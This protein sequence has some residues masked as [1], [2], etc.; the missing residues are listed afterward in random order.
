MVI[1]MTEKLLEIHDLKKHF[2]MRAGVLSNIKGYVKAVDGISLSVNKGET[3]GLVGESGC[4]KSTLGRLLLRLIEP[5]SGSC[6]INGVDIY[7]LKHNEMRKLRR[8]V[9]IIFQ[10]PYASLNPKITVGNIIGEPLKIFGIIKDKKVREEKV[11]NLLE[12]VGLDRE[13]FGRFP[14]EFSGGQRQRVCIARALALN[15]KLIV[16]DEAVSALDV[17]IR[18]QILNLLKDLQDKYDLTY[19]FISHDLS[20]VC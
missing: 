9:Q 12:V 10:D 5:T 18:S 13:H 8:D 14:H 7:K 4:G 17:S 15:P 20:V 19:I 2:A 1:V 11:K 6:L 16:C 3:F